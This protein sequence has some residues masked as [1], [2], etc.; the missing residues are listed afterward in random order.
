MYSMDDGM[1]IARQAS[2]DIEAWLNGIPETLGVENVEDEP[3]Y[4]KMDVD[5]LW[6]L[7]GACL[8]VE[9]KGDRHHK[10]R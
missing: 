1:S 2:R 6:H 5:L 8:K 10:N 9:I 3:E 4:Q 7:E